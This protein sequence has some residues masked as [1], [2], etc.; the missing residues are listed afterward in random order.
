MIENCE[1]TWA[2]HTQWILPYH[3]TYH[4]ISVVSSPLA[5][6]KIWQLKKFCFLLHSLFLSLKKCFK[7]LSYCITVVTPIQYWGLCW[8]IWSHC[9]SVVHLQHPS[10]T[11][12]VLYL[13]DRVMLSEAKIIFSLCMWMMFNKAEISK[14]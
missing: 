1:K 12:V 4:Q 10:S 11:V 3:R 14:A 9:F 5:L 2:F 7:R 8:T 13:Y 6:T